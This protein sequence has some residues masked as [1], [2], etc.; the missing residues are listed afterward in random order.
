MS[1]GEIASELQSSKWG[2]LISETPALPSPTYC[3]QK[4]YII[5]P[6]PEDCKGSACNFCLSA[7]LGQ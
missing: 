2:I 4:T 3:M 6:L 7:D 1:T 5:H